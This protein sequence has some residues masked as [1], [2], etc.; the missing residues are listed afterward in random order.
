MIQKINWNAIPKEQVNPMMVRQMVYGVKIMVVKM[1]FKDGFEVPWH[2]HENEQISQILKGI[3]RFWLE[4]QEDYIDLKA[5]EILVIP[6][7]VK[8]KALMIGA[9]EAIDTFSPPRQDWIDG[10]DNYLKK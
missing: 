7:N 3:C 6:A 1:T 2:Q 4:N 10:T 9:V 8:H 5:D